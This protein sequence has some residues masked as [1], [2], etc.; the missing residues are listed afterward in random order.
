MLQVEDNESEA[1]ET[2][3]KTTSDEAKLEQRLEDCR[4]FLSHFGEFASASLEDCQ[5]YIDQE[6]NVNLYDLLNWLRNPDT[7]AQPDRFSSVKDL[8]KY[9][10]EENKVF[11]RFRAE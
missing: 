11:P 2:P 6:L 3:D 9:S 8:G 4:R 7:A 10:Y 1:T 5:K